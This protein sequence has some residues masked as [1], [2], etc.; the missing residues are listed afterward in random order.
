MHLSGL[1]T[2]HCTQCRADSLSDCEKRA[3][4][5]WSAFM[6]LV[7]VAP[8]LAHCMDPDSAAAEADDESSDAEQLTLTFAWALLLAFLTLGAA[9]KEVRP[10]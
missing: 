4:G 3:A 10:R 9:E 2:I 5:S 1:M 8:T 6:A 7:G